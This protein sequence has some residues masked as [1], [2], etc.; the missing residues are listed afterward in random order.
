MPVRRM[1]AN[2]LFN[3]IV[4]ATGFREPRRIA[5]PGAPVPEMA[6]AADEF[7]SRFSDSAV[8][9]TE[10]E[11]SILQAL[12]LMN[13][14]LISDATDLGTS[15]TLVA[16]VEAPF[17]DTAG[18]VEM[19]FMA[20]LTRSPTPDEFADLAAY[21]DGGG[22]TGDSKKALTDVFWALLNSAEFALNH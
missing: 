17:M 20:T 6:T 16:I 13:G 12:A 4:Q 3:S 7:R 18:R 11:T 21:V 5:R 10:A 8:P 2:Q 9:R 14:K 19:L 15:E 1:T 22:A